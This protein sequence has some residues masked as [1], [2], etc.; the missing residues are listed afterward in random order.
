MKRIIVLLFIFS[1]CTTTKEPVSTGYYYVLNKGDQFLRL[2]ASYMGNPI[3]LEE[4]TIPPLDTT[5][6]FTAI[7]GSGG[8]VL[9]SNFFSTFQVTLVQPGNDSLLYSGVNNYDWKNEAFR[10]GGRNLVLFIEY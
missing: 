4:D 10:E 2:E 9:P 5:F 6:I 3:L 7:E 8:H 1:A